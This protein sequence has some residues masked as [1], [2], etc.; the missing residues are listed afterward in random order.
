MF[1]EDAERKK[2][3]LKVG[4]S[5]AS[6]F[7][8]TIS[9]LLMAY[10]VTGDW[11]KIGVIDTENKSASLYSNHV[12]PNGQAIGKFKV[13]NLDPPYSPERYVQAIDLFEKSDVEVCIIDSITHEWDGEGGCMSILDE[14]TKSSRSKNSYTQWATLTPRHNAFINKILHS[15]MHIFTTVRR[16]QDYEMT[17]NDSGKMEVVKVGTKEI[18]REGFEYELS[19]NFEFLND[20]HFVKASKD[21]TSLFS[22]STPIIISVETGK[23]LLEWANSGVNEIEFL[24]GS[25]LSANSRMEA[26]TIWNNYKKFQSVPE[27]IDAFK[28]I[29]KKYPKSE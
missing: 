12:L 11:S 17:K 14:L 27:V 8:K 15:D 3:K 2:V 19:V 24:C 21:R 7:G 25:I 9:S 16:K 26:T 22:E 29:A 5:G 20:S 13:I 23:Q 18:T 6:G 4:L 10:G 1:I 28:E